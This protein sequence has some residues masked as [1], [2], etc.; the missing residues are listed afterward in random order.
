MTIVAGVMN[1]QDYPHTVNIPS[2]NNNKLLLQIAIDQAITVK[3]KFSSHQSSTSSSTSSQKN[4][5]NGNTNKMK[6]L[7]YLSFKLYID[8]P[9][10]Q[11]H[12]RVK[13]TRFKIE[14]TVILDQTLTRR[15]IIFIHTTATPLI[16]R[17]KMRRM[18]LLKIGN[19]D[20]LH[21]NW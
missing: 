17:I 12:A 11:E 8:L 3:Y 2:S 9:K 7:V 16:K 20:L 21:M 6:L 5:K 10:Q 14:V 13:K 15:T 18:V 4:K 1:L 19:G